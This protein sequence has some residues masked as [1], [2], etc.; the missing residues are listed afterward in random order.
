MRPIHMTKLAFPI[1]ALATGALLAGCASSSS[2]SPSAAGASHQSSIPSGNPSAAGT[3]P[4]TAP[5]AAGPSVAATST[6]AG[7]PLTAKVPASAGS[8]TV[9]YIGPM[10]T[11]RLPI[12]KTVTG[13][14]YQRLAADLNA[15]KPVAPGAAQC[16]VETGE[17]SSVTVS[18]GGHT[19]VFLVNGSPCRGVRVTIDNKVQPLLAGS[20]T[21][22][23]QVRAI[24]GYIGVSHPLVS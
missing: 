13:A 3:S 8:A 11:K 16:N 5:S 20:G 1:A 6:Q 2:S 23:S 22:V 17:S 10:G 21:L 15:L 18:A 12:H 7:A 24:A 19:L 4:A 14:T 9:E